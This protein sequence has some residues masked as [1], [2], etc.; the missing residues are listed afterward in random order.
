ML[1]LLLLRRYSDGCW[2]TLCALRSGTVGVCPVPNKEQLIGVMLQLLD[3]N[4]EVEI[5][6]QQELQLELIQF[7]KRK[8]SDLPNQLISAL[9]QS[10][11][12][13]KKMRTFA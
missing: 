6:Q 8:T 1:V 9:S 3:G 12:R 10:L 11:R 7:R 4:V 5:V 2:M 13:R